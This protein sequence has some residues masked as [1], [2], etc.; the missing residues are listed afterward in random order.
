MA[1]AVLNRHV[2][3]LIAV[4]M[5]LAGITPAVAGDPP[6]YTYRTNANDVRL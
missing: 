1:T 3:P 4:L 2:R 6:E 5:F